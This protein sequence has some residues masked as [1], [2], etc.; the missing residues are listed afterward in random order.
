LLAGIRERAKRADADI[1]VTTE[2][3]A[4]KLKTLMAPDPCWVVRLV[5]DIPVGRERLE[6]VVLSAAAGCAM[7]SCA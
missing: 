1:F 5:T 7:E 4:V 6:K 3:D 2:K